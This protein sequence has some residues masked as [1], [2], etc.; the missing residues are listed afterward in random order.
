MVL[1][2]NRV[3]LLDNTDGLSSGVVAISAFT[4]FAIAADGATICLHPWRSSLR[5]RASVSF[6][7]TSRRFDLPRLYRLADARVLPI[8]AWR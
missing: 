2:T 8:R 7:T 3:N 1:I 4:F 5:A 6:D